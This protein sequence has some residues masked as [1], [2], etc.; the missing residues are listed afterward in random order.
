MFK[1]CFKWSIYIIYFSQIQVLFQL[2]FLNTKIVLCEALNVKSS[3]SITSL[4][5]IIFLLKPLP[6]FKVAF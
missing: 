5:F 6:V 1:V 4:L 2:N 3:L